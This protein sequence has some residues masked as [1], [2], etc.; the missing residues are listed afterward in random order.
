MNNS[1][2]S[3]LNK[4]ISVNSGVLVVLIAI[5]SILVVKYNDVT[6][7]LAELEQGQIMVDQGQETQSEG[8]ASAAPAAKSLV[9]VNGTDEI[10]LLQDQLSRKLDRLE[11]EIAN[12]AAA[13]ESAE[14]TL[15]SFEQEQAQAD[16]QIDEL[17]SI[18]TDEVL[19]DRADTEWSEFAVESLHNSVNQ[20]DWQGIELVSANCGSTVCRAE[21]ALDPETIEENIHRLPGLIPWNAEIFVSVPNDD[22]GDAV[23][24]I[25]RE[26]HQLPRQM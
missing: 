20:T 10:R 24:F 2:N 5:L 26:D 25:A 15:E 22:S 13:N 16:A 7:K 12:V 18:M 8:F 11:R 3:I 21:L 6:V 9:Q 1:N 19:T 4:I 14:V 23:V 17:V